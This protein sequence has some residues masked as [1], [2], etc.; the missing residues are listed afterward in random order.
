[1]DWTREPPKVPGWY[2]LTCYRRKPELVWVYESAGTLGVF[3]HGIDY[4]MRNFHDAHW[5]GPIT[6]PTG[7]E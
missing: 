1:M 4:D 6:V 3:R 2:W 5:L 7:P